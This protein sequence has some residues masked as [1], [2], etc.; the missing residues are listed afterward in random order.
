MR[1]PLNSSDKRKRGYNMGLQSI[2]KE[3]QR[4]LQLPTIKRNQ[5]L[6]DLMDEMEM[7]YGAMI[8]NPETQEQ[9]NEIIKLYR[10]I[11]QSREFW[12]PNQ[13]I[14]QNTRKKDEIEE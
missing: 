14:M 7:T 13:E 3:Y 12:Q 6:V 11:S 8:F 1:I 5:L 2:E 4:A 10:K 9:D